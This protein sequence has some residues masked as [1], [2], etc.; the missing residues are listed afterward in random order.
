MPLATAHPSFHEKTK[1]KSPA[2]LTLGLYII[3][4]HFPRCKDSAGWVCSC[5][6][7]SCMGGCMALVLAAVA[8]IPILYT[9][10]NLYISVISFISAY[11][12]Y[13]F[14]STMSIIIIIN[15]NNNIMIL[16]IILLLPAPRR[17]RRRRRRH[18]HHHRH[19]R[20]HH[21]TTDHCMFHLRIVC[22]L[23]KSAAGIW[24]S[25][26]VPCWHFLRFPAFVPRCFPL[27][28]RD[29]TWTTANDFRLCVIFGK[30]VCMCKH[31]MQMRVS[32]KCCRHAKP[33]QPLVYRFPVIPRFPLGS[34]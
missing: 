7:L 29:A 20:H 9:I 28:R 10:Y 31:N 11:P 6:N 16:M 2:G 13:P 34:H 1:C 15:N 32:I 17:R 14:I 30:R 8:S 27:P 19:R 5:R 25:C 12:S 3:H 4:Y 23:Q 21:H 26:S 24:N 33:L 18:C 22:L